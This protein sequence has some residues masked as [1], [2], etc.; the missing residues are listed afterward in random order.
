MVWTCLF[1]IDHYFVDMELRTQIYG[2][3]YGSKSQ[4]G[5]DFAKNPDSG[6]ATKQANI[7]SQFY[8]CNSINT[9]EKQYSILLALSPKFSWE[10]VIF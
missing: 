8:Y 2:R 10:N 6:R 1:H 9:Y 7:S 4:F 3:A 5:A